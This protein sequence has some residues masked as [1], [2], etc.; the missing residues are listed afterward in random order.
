MSELQVTDRMSAKQLVIS[1]NAEI[2]FINNPKTNKVFFTCGSKRGYV[3]PAAQ[4]KMT[5]PN[6]TLDDFQYAMVAKPGEQAIPCLMVVGNSEQNVIK[7]L[8]TSLLH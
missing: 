5:D 2:Q 8:G 7:K 1:E 4:K 6:C 3:S